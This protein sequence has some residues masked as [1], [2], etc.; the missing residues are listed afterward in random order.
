MVEAIFG[1]ISEVLVAIF[2]YQ[3]AVG[4]C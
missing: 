2:F 4:R 1:F 3:Q